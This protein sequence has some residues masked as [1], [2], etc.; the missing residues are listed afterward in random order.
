MK[1]TTKENL[2]LKSMK[3]SKVIRP[4]T[5]ATYRGHYERV[6]DWC[7]VTR[8]TKLF[9]YIVLIQVL[10]ITVTTAMFLYHNPCISQ[11]VLG[12]SYVP[13]VDEALSPM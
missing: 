7:E 12:W 4:F 6:L 1:S 11:D 13:C 8:M 10:Y 2:T 9:L 5:W 3:D